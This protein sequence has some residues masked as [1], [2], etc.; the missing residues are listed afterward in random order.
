MINKKDNNTYELDKDI[1]IKYVIDN[2]ESS[3]IDNLESSEID[4]NK[5]SKNEQFDVKIIISDNRNRFDKIE[6]K[7]TFVIR[8]EKSVEIDNPYYE[9]KGL[10]EGYDGHL[11]VNKK[12]QLDENGKIIVNRKQQYLLSGD[13]YTKNWLEKYEIEYKNANP[14]YKEHKIFT[15]NDEKIYRTSL[16]FSVDVENPKIKEITVD[17]VNISET[18]TLIVTGKY[19]EIKVKASDNNSQSGIVAYLYTVNAEGNEKI[20]GEPIVMNEGTGIKYD[21]GGDKL[22][23]I[24]AGHQLKGNKDK[25]PVGPGSTTLKAKVA[26]GTA[27]CVT[28]I[29]EYEINLIVSLMLRDELLERGYNVIMIRETHDVNISNAERA[30]IAN[31]ADADAFVRIHANGSEN[32]SVEGVETICQTKNNPYNSALYEESKKL[33]T[34]VLDNMVEKMGCTRRKVW[35][36]DTMSGINWCTV[37]VTIV[38]MGYMSN[39][40]E[41][42][43]LASVEYQ[44][45]IVE[46]IADGIDAFFE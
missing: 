6:K 11:W 9:L 35:E 27:G 15:K 26:S 10:V 1:S 46:G 36:T 19:V 23:A 32:A 16:F 17:G 33:S 18:D 42:K 41:D 38:E 22:V 29:A 13:A 3:E 21:I 40:K 25:E 30:M 43:L 2:S 12:S 20:I 39:P 5:I 28:K 14:Y 31:N 8:S 45:K 37:P 7:I 4:A 24:D 44:K 34:C